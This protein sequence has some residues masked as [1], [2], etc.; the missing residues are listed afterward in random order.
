MHVSLGTTKQLQYAILAEVRNISTG[1]REKKNTTST[2]HHP[3]IREKHMRAVSGV[4]R[5]ASE[6]PNDGSEQ[7]L[8]V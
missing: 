8:L 3:K 1:C 4:H 5:P 2:S 6:K 7:A